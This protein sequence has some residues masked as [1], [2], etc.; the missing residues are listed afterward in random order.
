MT[1]IWA[2][3][4]AR[5]AALRVLAV[6]VLVSCAAGLFFVYQKRFVYNVFRGPFSLSSAELAG[7]RSAEVAKTYFVKVTGSDSFDM[8]LVKGSIKTAVGV[9]VDR[10]IVAEYYALIVGGKFLIVETPKLH[11]ARDL[12]VVGT[13]SSFPMDLRMLLKKKFGLQ[14]LRQDYYPFYLK[15]GSVKGQAYAIVAVLLLIEW[16]FLTAAWPSLRI[17]RAPG[18][19][20]VMKKI[21]SWGDPYQVSAEIEREIREPPKRR[22][23]PWKVTRSYLVLSRPFGFDVFRFEDILWSYPQVTNHFISFIPTG[24]T[25][26]ARLFF[27]NGTA[28]VRGHRRAVDELLALVAERAPWAAAGFSYETLARFKKDRARFQEEIEAAKRESRRR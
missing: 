21:G 25:Y 14:V 11:S 22:I 9:E 20:R 26:R 3:A 27:S 19:G 7:I 10:S 28:V 17:L 23:G 2:A 6:L 15:A 18:S 16:A 8:E 4:M 5:R 12:A 1:E 13:L 24:S